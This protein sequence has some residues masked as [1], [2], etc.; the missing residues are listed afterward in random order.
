MA[1]DTALTLPTNRRPTLFAIGADELALMDLLVEA[2]GDISDPATEAAVDA[3]AAELA[4]RRGEKLDS[5][6][7]LLKQLAMHH[8][9]CQE[10]AQAWTWRAARHAKAAESVRGVVSRYLAAAGLTKVESAKGVR[11]ALVANGGKRAVRL[12]A[13][14]PEDLPAR[15]ARTVTTTTPDKD[16]IRKALEAG[17]SLDFAVLE[18]RG[19][20][21]S[22]K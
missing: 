1:T 22:I 21:L 13:T 7:A 6:D 19:T 4:T 17:E 16:A 10:E 3:W 12:D 18:E 5:V 14:P 2:G 15:F 9:A 8:M 11:F 20:R